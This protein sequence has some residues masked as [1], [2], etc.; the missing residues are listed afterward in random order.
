MNQ[1]DPIDEIYNMYLE[2]EETP[3][4]MEVMDNGLDMDSDL[5]DRPSDL[6]LKL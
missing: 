4:I 1:L 5:E 6:Y 2:D 3:Q